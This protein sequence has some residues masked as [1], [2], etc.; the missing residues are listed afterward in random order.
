MFTPVGRRQGWNGSG[1]TVDM[2]PLI[3]MVFILLIF[4]MVTST[5]VRD[6]GID[7]R[8]PRAAHSHVLD[9]Q[10]L[11]VSVT[12]NGAIYVE[13]RRVD[14]DG[15]RDRVARSVR[16]EGNPSVIIVP[17]E[18]TSAGRLVE[19]MDTAQFAGAKDISVATRAKKARSL[20]EGEE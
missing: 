18:R 19:I 2:A 14:L 17:D 15:L 20:P 8:R 12:M 1:T 10:S 4:F 3:D 5:S 7:V 16:R 11:R 6:V 13:G 9:S